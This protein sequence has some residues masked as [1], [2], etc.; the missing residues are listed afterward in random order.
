MSESGRIHEEL[1][2]EW[3]QLQATWLDSR[4]VWKDGVASLFDKR[5]MSPLTAEIPAFLS[6]LEALGEELQAARRE[7]R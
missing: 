5:F 7:L 4:T 1:A 3:N 2:V 6:V